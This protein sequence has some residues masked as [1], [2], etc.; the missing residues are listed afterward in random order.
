MRFHFGDWTFDPYSSLITLGIM[1]VV[2]YAI[3]S[4]RKLMSSVAR[5]T[6]DGV[7]L[8]VSRVA[9]QRVAARISLRRYGQLQLAGPT[10]YLNV[11]GNTTEISLDIDQIFVP[12][13]LE[14]A[15][16]LQTFGHNEVTTLG[17]RI[18]IT[19]DP[20]SGKS[21]FA[22]RIFR[23]ECAKAL[24]KPNA[25][26]FP[27]LIELRRL[28]FPKGTSAKKLGDWLYNY[29]LATAK[30]YDMYEA[31]RCFSA[32]AVTSGLLIILD[33]LDEV[34]AATYSVA[35]AAINGL[36]SKL[37]QMG[38]NNIVV[39]T[40]RTQFHLQVGR[41]YRET[42]PI[43]LSLKRFSPTDIYAF[44]IRWPFEDKTKNDHVIRIYNDLTDRP[45]LREMCT[46]PLILSMYV[47]QDQTSGHQLTPESR[48]AFYKQVTEELLIRRR[49]KQLGPSDTQ[50][51][52]RRQRERI[53]GRI[54][55]EHLCDGNQPANLIPWEDG[56]RIVTQI[57]GV[58]DSAGS[59]KILREISK[60]TG[61]ISEE[62]E[63]ETFRFIHLTFCEFLAAVEATQGRSDG[64]DV[65]REKH[66][67]FSNSPR[68]RT[69]L[70]EVIPFAASLLPEHAQPLAI[71]H[72]SQL[73]DA[74]MLALTFLETKRY[75]HLIWRNF[76]DEYRNDLVSR[77]K[78]DWT[79]EW[80]SEVHLFLVVAS[81][82]NR[83]FGLM[84]G[85]EYTNAIN[86]FFQ[87][88]VDDVEETLTKLIASYAEQ[89]AASAFRVS[90]LCGVDILSKLPA[91]VVDNV[92]Q[93]AFLAI[94]IE[95]ASR[96]K[97]NPEEWASLLAEA[98]L[99]SPAAAALLINST[100]RPWA[101][102]AKSVS[103][104]HQWQL[105]GIIPSSLYSDCLTIAHSSKASRTYLRLINLFRKLQSPP[106][107][108][109]TFHARYLRGRAD[110]FII[111][112]YLGISA[113]ALLG[114]L[115][116]EPLFPE[117]IHRGT[118][119][120]LRIPA[121]LILSI[122][123]AEI[124]FVSLFL[125]LE[126]R[127]KLCEQVTNLPSKVQPGI[128]IAMFQSLAKLIILPF[129]RFFF[130]GARVISGTIRPEQLTRNSFISSSE[131]FLLARQ[132]LKNDNAIR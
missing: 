63:G 59:E 123:T 60:E 83:S 16:S 101:D 46:N 107:R 18:R 40:M 93:P 108:W 54:A 58:K 61:L 94:T 82:A 62:R 87:H 10:R 100:Q 127:S 50:T 44:L 95:R 113:A 67:D 109:M 89:D 129:A 36:S 4:L 122:S 26:R 118:S 91:V 97:E 43:S 78:N 37:E 114:I 99:R 5:Y 73:R 29:L 23:D 71:E 132:Q 56:K 90:T 85:I 34:A 68:T 13:V 25:A 12:L 7:F 130:R 121:I 21:S 98:G 76:I 51:V 86:L 22:K 80:L 1:P 131:M 33:G 41:A 57:M 52:L 105:P 3:A 55:F 124:I 70:A 42:F 8:G 14:R 69:R 115:F 88:F 106:S 84:Q 11:P 74:R 17:R 31:E 65:L 104:T 75:E 32:Y 39:L 120:L 15:G 126:K 96:D 9:T 45:T 53:L 111:A 116:L 102:L 27:L 24:T 47:A 20:G 2:L 48:S 49:A 72:V 119:G 19:G 112:I 103:H 66:R 128:L 77:S 28:D 38:S 92:D 64:W 117:I 81:D 6:I 35:E 125:A 79:T 110:I 30:S